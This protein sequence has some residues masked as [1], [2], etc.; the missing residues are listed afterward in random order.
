MKFFKT[1]KGIII[2]VSVIIA[3]ILII[4]HIVAEKSVFYK[5]PYEKTDITS[6]LDK[7]QLSDKDYIL[8]FEQTGISPTAAKELIEDGN[9]QFIQK[10]HELYFNKPLSKKNY[11][12]F[13]ITLEE[14]NKTQITPIVPLK[15]GDILV[16]FNTRTL[17]WR[18]GHCGL[19][20][21]ESGTQ[22]LEHMAIGETSCIT[23]AFYWGRYPAF[24][25]LRYRDEK[26]SQKAADY[27][28]DNLVD[29]PY[30]IFAGV[31]KKDKSD[32][33]EP[34][35]HCSH[36]VWQAYKSQKV[37]IDKNDGIFVTPR[38]IADSGNLQVVQIYGLNPKGYTSRIL[39]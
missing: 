32:K 24:L 9:T 19:V 36:I 22:L 2:T 6:T 33:K 15:K 11:I 18:H 38:D 10:L 31:F 30:N 13:P 20:L 1:K 21:D 17:D 26:I 7:K 4:R 37:D 23:D 16:T 39:K 27:A 29:I 25:V 12:A 28:K 14:M 5:V 3:V 35:S 8:I 34:S